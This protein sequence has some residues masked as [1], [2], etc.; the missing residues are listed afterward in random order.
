MS[1][2]LQSILLGCREHWGQDGG[3]GQ[4]DDLKN[5]NSDSFF[6]SQ[7]EDTS[8]KRGHM[9]TLIQPKF[10]KSGDVL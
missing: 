8:G 10:Q 4:T 7:K 2:Y 9:V 5:P 3:V 1:R 6:M